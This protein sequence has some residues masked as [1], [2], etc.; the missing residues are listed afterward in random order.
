MQEI[1]I[2]EYNEPGYARPMNYGTWCVA[3][4]NYCDAFDKD[5]YTYLESHLETDEVFVLLSGTATLIIGKDFKEIPMETHKVYNVKKGAWHA[6]N[7]S[8]DA[9]V[10]IVEENNTSPENTEF[11]Y[12]R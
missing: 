4:A 10:L 3:F 9:H 12:F 2:L 8:T 7:M 1:E 11:Y 5:K 6:L